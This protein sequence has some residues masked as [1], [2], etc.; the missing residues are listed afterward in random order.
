MNTSIYLYIGTGKTYTMGILDRVK[1]Q[2]SGIIPKSL[3]H[4]FS[5]MASHGRDSEWTVSI[6]FLQ[7]YLESIQDLLVPP[8]EDR[9]E[10]NLAIREDPKKGCFVD[11]LQEY[12]V[13]N[14]EEAV[15]LL[16]WG[17]ENR[18]MASTLM[19]ITSSRSHTVLTV[20]VQQVI[21]ALFLFLNFFCFGSTHQLLHGFLFA[22]IP[23]NCNANSNP[24]ITLSYHSAHHLI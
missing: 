10:E 14:Y 19:N 11:G 9:S 1:T 22:S 23:L 16:N 24:L 18:V 5:H 8:S 2:P 21:I 12:V 17:L 3:K 15:E 20:Y 7:I 6:S 13:R 4:I